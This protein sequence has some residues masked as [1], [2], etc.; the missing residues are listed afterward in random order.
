MPTKSQERYITI[1]EAAD[2]AGVDVR[3]VHRWKEKGRIHEIR[4]RLGHVQV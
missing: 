4:D 3:T 2:E 1:K